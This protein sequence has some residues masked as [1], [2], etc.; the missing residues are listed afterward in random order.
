[1]KTKPMFLILLVFAIG[2]ISNTLAASRTGSTAKATEYRRYKGAKAIDGD[3]F[4]YRGQRYRL[5]EYNAPEIGQ[6]GSPRATKN[7]QKKLDS[8]YRYKSVA[9]DVYGR[10]VVEEANPR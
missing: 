1:M 9:R 4:R 3:T 7:L 5:R 10:S 6:P 2:T 8:A